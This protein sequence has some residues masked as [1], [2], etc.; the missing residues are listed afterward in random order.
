MWTHDMIMAYVTWPCSSLKYGHVRL[1][2][3]SCDIVFV[4]KDCFCHG[5]TAGHVHAGH[6]TMVMLVMSQRLGCK[7]TDYLEKCKY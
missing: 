2:L 4:N 6:V 7:F 1:S 3:W 5:D